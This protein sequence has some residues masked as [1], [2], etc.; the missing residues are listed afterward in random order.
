[1]SMSDAERARSEDVF[2]RERPP[3]RHGLPSPRSG[4]ELD[5]IR[6]ARG[7]LLAASRTQ[8]AEPDRGGV[9]DHGSQVGRADRVLAASWVLENSDRGARAHGA[10]D[11]RFGRRAVGTRVWSVAHG[12][13]PLG[14]GDRRTQHGAP[15]PVATRSAQTPTT[16]RARSRRGESAVDLRSGG[17]TDAAV[18][19]ADFASDGGERPDR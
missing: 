19:A 8:R 3:I 4:T 16:G 17:S 18:R 1:M 13:R 5:V 10:R 6:H 12:L 14:K 7:A 11:A 9:L 15:R 2:V